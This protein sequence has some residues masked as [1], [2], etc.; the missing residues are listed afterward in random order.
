MVTTADLPTLAVDLSESDSED[1][2]GFAAENKPHPPPEK[3]L[4]NENGTSVKYT[5]DVLERQ[6]EPPKKLS[7]KRPGR[8]NN[9]LS[10]KTRSKS[11]MSYDVG[12]QT[13][14]LADVPTN[15][16]ALSYD[17]G[18]QTSSCMHIKATLHGSMK[19]ET[20]HS[21]ETEVRGK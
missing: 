11:T 19:S 10:A 20:T 7:R 2:E 14:E 15:K 12:S 4:Y 21:A 9:S 5:Q 13:T 6:D 16:S 18:H 17:V 1:E 3:I 8:S